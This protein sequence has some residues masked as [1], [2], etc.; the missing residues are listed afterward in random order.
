MKKSPKVYLDA[1]EYSDA[2]D[3]L[4][5][6]VGMILFSFAKNKCTSKDLIL[7]NFIARAAVSQKSV[8]SLYHA[9]DFP[10]AW[11]IHRTILDRMF[12]LHSIGEKS[13]YEEFDDWSFF[14]QYKGQNRL[15]S[16]SEFKHETV[17]REYDLTPQQKERIKSLSSSIPKWRR[18]K[19]KDVAKD[20]GMSFL[21]K[22]GYDYASK[23]V[24]PMSDDGQQD[25]YTITGLEPRPNYPSQVSVLSNTVLAT[26][27]I[28]QTALNQSSFSWIKLLWDFIDQVRLILDGGSSDEY[29]IT[30]LKLC[31]L[32][33]SNDIC[34]SKNA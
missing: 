20:M 5:V 1:K 24:H 31:R 11:V 4:Y 26:T 17:G 28:I 22:Y 13:E 23:F 12:H 33:E 6:A 8:I 32:Y 27:M 18:P 9:E 10:N 29:K 19:A 21:Y 30:M 16:D 25:F 15:R 34:V 3:A 7:R 2:A 14:M